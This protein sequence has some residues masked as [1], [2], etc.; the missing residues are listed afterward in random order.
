MIN[1]WLTNVAIQ[2]AMWYLGNFAILFLFFIICTKK[3]S[4]IKYLQ[5]NF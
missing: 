1:I 5:I 4:E 3:S 2:K